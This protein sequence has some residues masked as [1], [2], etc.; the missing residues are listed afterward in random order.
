METRQKQRDNK[1]RNQ[2]MRKEQQKKCETFV[3]SKAESCNQE[4]RNIS[5]NETQIQES[6]E[7]KRGKRTRKVIKKYSDYESLIS[8]DSDSESKTS[9]SIYTPSEANNLENEYESDLE[10]AEEW[11]DENL[12]HENTKDQNEEAE[13]HG[14]FKK[15]EKSIDKQNETCL[16]IGKKG[17]KIY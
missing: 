3:Q 16:P 7:Q 11:I 13:K 5:K 14:Q 15:L 8:D 17:V 12:E 2:N 1:C 6:D 10:S 4:Q 9:G